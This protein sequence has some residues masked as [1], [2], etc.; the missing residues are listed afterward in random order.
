MRKL[1]VDHMLPKG[2]KN[3]LSTSAVPNLA[4]AALLRS[5]ANGK[6][7]TIQYILSVTPSMVDVAM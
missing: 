4:T 3:A 1:N 6:I 7:K 5:S 2:S